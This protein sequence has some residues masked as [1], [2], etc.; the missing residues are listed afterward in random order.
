MAGN[1][2]RIWDQRMFLLMQHCISTGACDSQRDFLTIIG[3][4]ETGLAQVRQGKQSFRH[5]HFL[6]AAKKFNIDLN[7]FYG[8]P[9]PMKR[10]IKNHKTPIALLKEAVLAVEAEVKKNI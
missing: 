9:S 4:R 6:A 5:Q 7:W 8:L 3:F 2:L 10:I 1:K